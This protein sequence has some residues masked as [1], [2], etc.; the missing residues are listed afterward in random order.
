MVSKTI[1]NIS[2]NTFA[3]PKGYRT[4][5]RSKQGNSSISRKSKLATPGMGGFRKKLSA[6][7]ISEES[8]A[9]IT[10][11]RRTGTNTHYESA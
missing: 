3:A 9:L 8:A 10:N 2:E 5:I 4:F 6:E 11:A 1:T 7:G